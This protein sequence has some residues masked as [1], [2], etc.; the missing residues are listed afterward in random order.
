MA[1]RNGIA[2]TGELC[3][4]DVQVGAADTARLDVDQQLVR[5]GLGQAQLHRFQGRAGGEH[6]HGLHGMAFTALL[7]AAG[8]SRRARSGAGGTTTPQVMIIFMAASTVI[9]SSTTWL[10][11]TITR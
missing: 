1:G 2:K 5:G 10:R 7:Q 4:D 11:G 8:I 9:S 3:I 6:S